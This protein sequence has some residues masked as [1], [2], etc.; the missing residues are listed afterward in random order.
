MHDLR[1]FCTTVTD[2]DVISL[3]LS[4]PGLH[5][6]AINNLES[7]VTGRE[8]QIHRGT[9]PGEQPLLIVDGHWLAASCIL[10]PQILDLA[11]THLGTTRILAAIPFRDT[12][13]IFDEADAR[14]RQ[15]IVEMNRQTPEDGRKLITLG[16]FR[17]LTTG[18]APYTEP[19]TGP[20]AS[21]W[22]RVFHF[23]RAITNVSSPSVDMR[24][25]QES[26]AP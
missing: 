11:V 8:I 15:T 10:L 12:L 20:P 2:S 1:G 5:D 18:I 9:G 21:L 17:L 14:R 22:T 26:P 13:V 23:A 24:K 7:L 25:V 6:R 16:L 4:I 3:G 19:V